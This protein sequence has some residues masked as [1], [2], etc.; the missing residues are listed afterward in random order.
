MVWIKKKDKNPFH[1]GTWIN[2]KDGLLLT[3]ISDI[4]FD[5]QRNVVIQ[6]YRKQELSGYQIIHTEYLESQK[7]AMEYAKRYMMIHKALKLNRDA[8]G[9]TNWGLP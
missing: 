7:E 2:T 8:W 5:K 1:H 4:G 6:N 3:I 9:K